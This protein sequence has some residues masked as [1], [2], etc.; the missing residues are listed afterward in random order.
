MTSPNSKRKR[1][2]LPD[3]SSF[4]LPDVITRA[5]QLGGEEAAFATVHEMIDVSE[6]Q[7]RDIPSFPGATWKAVAPQFDLD[8]NRGI[9]Q[10][11]RFEVPSAILPPSFHREVMIESLKWLD[12]YQARD[13]QKQE[14]ARLR[15]M[16]AVRISLNP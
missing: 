4:N 10:L 14:A 15:L 7:G 13:A 8:P 16:D 5:Q 1:L 6:L 3:L 11:E 12:V 2:D 9:N